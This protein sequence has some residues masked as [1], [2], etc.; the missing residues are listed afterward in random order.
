MLFFLK[1]T[2]N[3]IEAC[4]QKYVKRLI[5]TS[6]IDVVRSKDSIVDGDESLPY[7]PTDAKGYGDTKARAEKA[8][9]Q[10][11]DRGLDKGRTSSSF[12]TNNDLN[13]KVSISN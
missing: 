9:L 12:L 13:L 3:I 11:N 4:I 6:S 1:G 10:A 8:V 2:R 5:Y 7:I